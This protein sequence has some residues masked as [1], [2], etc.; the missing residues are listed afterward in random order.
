MTQTTDPELRHA[1]ATLARNLAAVIEREQLTQAQLSEQSGVS[2]RMIQYVLGATSAASVDTLAAL[3]HALEARIAELVGESSPPEDTRVSY[4]LETQDFINETRTLVAR[5][6]ADAI[7]SRG[8]ARS[9]I[10]S[11]AGVSRS[12]LYD[13]LGEKRAA[14]IDFLIRLAPVLM[15]ELEDFFKES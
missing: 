2:E 1:R 14:T 13:V 11:D 8:I 9:R 12:M 6:I 10:A 15:L 4:E 3:A 5:N 7:T